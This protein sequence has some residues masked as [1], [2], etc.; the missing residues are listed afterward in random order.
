[1]NK[2]ILLILSLF[3]SINI[4]A[5]M[6]E[7]CHIDLFESKTLQGAGLKWIREKCER[8]N[9]LYVS[10]LGES[11]LTIT[12]SRY[13]RF[14]RNVSERIYKIGSTDKKRY[15]LTCVLYDNESREEVDYK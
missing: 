14:D 12:I 15:E 9:I 2:R 13:C 1:M 3:V 5:D 6:D 10:G 11:F 8:N 7:I 4:W